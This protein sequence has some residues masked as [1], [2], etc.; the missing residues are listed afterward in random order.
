MDIIKE[1]VDSLNAVIKIKL[2]PEDYQSQVDKSLKEYSKKVSLPGFRPGKVP[3]GMVKKMH[4]KSILIEEINKILSNS[5][6]NY[7]SENKI[8][9]LG[10]PLPKESE[11]AKIDWDNQKNMEFSY[12]LGLSPQF[13]IE[14]DANHQF[15]SYI[16]KTDDVLVQTQVDN[17]AK[18]Y[19]KVSVPAESGLDDLIHADFVELGA[20]NSPVEEGVHKASS[21]LINAVKDEETRNKLIGLKIGD[22]LIV[23]PTK[24]SDNEVDLAA[25]LGVNKDQ[26]SNVSSKFEIT[27]KELSHL[28]PAELNQELFDKVFGDGNVKTEQEFKERVKTELQSQYDEITEGKL[29]NDVADYLIENLKIILP[30]EFLKKWMV[31]V[32]EKPVTLEQISTEYDNYSKGLRWQLIENKIIKEN[33]IKVSVEDVKEYAAKSL[34]GYYSRYGIWNVNPAELEAM[35]GNMLKDKEE[36]KR[37]YERVYDLKILEVFKKQYKLK[38]KELTYEEYLNEI[39]PKK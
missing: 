22:K 25:M 37:L 33:A 31:A 17:F 39:Q 29:L 5:L 38:S 8:E 28:K 2:T 19:G 20:D 4:G 12:D 1:Q 9:I 6:H 15:E 23:E 21:I 18:R 24:L 26:L 36:L 3:S 10:N 16:I 14:I 7:I 13:N 34:K 30:D 32:S 35:V 27:V 11:A